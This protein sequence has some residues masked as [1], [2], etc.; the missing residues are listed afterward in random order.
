MF[1]WSRYFAKEQDGDFV[2]LALELCEGSLASYI[3]R[4]SAESSGVSGDLK[5]LHAVAAARR[6]LEEAGSSIQP[7]ADASAAEAAAGEPPS[8][9]SE[10]LSADALPFVPKFGT[11]LASPL[12]PALHR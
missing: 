11:W 12:S 2:Y 8:E 10:K 3:D 4:N 1:L 9:E 5:G 7:Q 6:A